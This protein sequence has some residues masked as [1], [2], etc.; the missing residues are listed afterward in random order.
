MSTK[1]TEIPSETDALLS[2]IESSGIVVPSPADVKGYL[3]L[4]MV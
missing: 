1:S 3:W 2:R 4:F